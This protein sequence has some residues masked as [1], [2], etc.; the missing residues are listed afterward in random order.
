MLHSR[1][2]NNKINR[3]HERSPR[4]VYTDQSSKFKE[5]L[6]AATGGVL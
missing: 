2:M 1:T 6:E 3:I 5:L 4:I